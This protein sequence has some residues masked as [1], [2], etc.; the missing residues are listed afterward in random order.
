[1]G[2]CS[3]WRCKANQVQ[4]YSVVQTLW[5]SSPQTKSNMSFTGCTQPNLRNLKSQPK[6]AKQKAMLPLSP[7]AGRSQEVARPALLHRHLKS[8]LKD[9]FYT[10]L[11]LKSPPYCS[12]G[13]IT[14][15]LLQER[16]RKLTLC[17]GLAVAVSI[18]Y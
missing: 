1:M 14:S 13:C 8:S 11:L 3:P 6:A 5:P 17:H 10:D 4:H 9:L 7:E 16:R 12:K 2:P 15:M 18:I